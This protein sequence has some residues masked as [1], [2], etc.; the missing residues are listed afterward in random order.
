MILHLEVLDDESGTGIHD[1]LAWLRADEEVDSGRLVEVADPPEEGDMAGGGILAAIETAVVSR[2]VLVAVAGAV[3][4]WLSARAANRRTRI[5]IR[6]GENAVEIDTAHLDDADK[7][8]LKIH[9][10]LR[11]MA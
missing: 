5:R 7:I 10:E 1:L 11:D 8:A 3:G 4:G 6:R 2:E 9:Q